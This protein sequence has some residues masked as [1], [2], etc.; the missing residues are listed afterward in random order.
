MNTEQ[1]I[2]ELNQVQ[3]QIEKKLLTDD[4]VCKKYIVFQMLMVELAERDELKNH[5]NINDMITQELIDN[6]DDDMLKRYRERTMKYQKLKIIKTL[7]EKKYE[8]D[9]EIKDEE[10]V[11]EYK[12]YNFEF[13]TELTFK[14]IIYG[15][16]N[17]YNICD[18]CDNMCDIDYTQ[19]YNSC[20]ICQDCYDEIINEKRL[21]VKEYVEYHITDII[22]YSEDTMFI[23]I[24]P[25]NEE[26]IKVNFVDYTYEECIKRIDN[27]YREYC[28]DSEL[29][30]DSDEYDSEKED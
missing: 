13:S 23:S 26:C 20:V 29:I 3:E 10:Y 30:I 16:E 1:F 17:E 19:I 9:V 5:T 18:E 21:K 6:V 24:P 7:I 15:I 11:F 28:I 8:V 12:G 4:Y 27:K 14:D 22:N 2:T 25:Y